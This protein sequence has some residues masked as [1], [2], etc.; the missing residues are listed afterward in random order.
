MVDFLLH[1]FR[2]GSRPFQSLSAIPDDKAYAIMRSLFVEG[3]VF[4]ERFRDPSSYLSFRK[5]VERRIRNEFLSKGGLPKNEYPIY[6]VLGRPKWTESV[7]DAQT[8]STTEEIAIPLSIL[9]PE[10]VSFTYPDSM[11]S[12][13]M[14]AEKNPEYYEPDYHGKVFTLVE[15][16]G[17]IK[18]KGLPGDR[19][20]TK[21]PKHLAHYIEA[22]VWNQRRLL[23]YYGQTREY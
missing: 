18:Q 12:A 9:S 2:K 14:E 15:I 19:W 7:A 8:V 20:Q 23:E 6:F 3:S 22:Q 5:Q 16:E 11:V 4:W 21:M 17:I 10:D 1:F 13:M